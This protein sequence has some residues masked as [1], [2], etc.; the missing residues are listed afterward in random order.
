MHRHVLLRQDR[1]EREAA[2]DALGRGHHVRL[3]ARPLVRP[4]LAGAPHAGLHLVQRQQQAELV[5]AAA[6]VAQ[7]IERGG[8]HA[9]LALD[10]LHH[11]ARGVR[12]DGVPHRV[13]VAEGH[14]VEA[15]H[16]RPEAR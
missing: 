10:R 12:P 2:A 11:D 8:A 16:R 15:L 5:A 1:A 3:D 4:E 9:A 14:V 13:H 7:E 6:Q